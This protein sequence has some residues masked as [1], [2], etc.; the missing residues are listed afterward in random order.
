MKEIQSWKLF[1]LASFELC[2]TLAVYDA[3]IIISLRGEGEVLIMQP[4]LNTNL[5][6]F[7]L[8]ATLLIS[9]TRYHAKMQHTD[10]DENQLL[11]ESA[12]SSRYQWASTCFLHCWSQWHG[13]GSKIHSVLPDVPPQKHPTLSR[14]REI[15]VNKSEKYILWNQRNTNI[16]IL[17]AIMVHSV[18]PPR[19]HWQHLTYPNKR[20]ARD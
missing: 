11:W 5:P 3:I 20:D 2:K 9:S 19:K 14:I 13:L 15:W 18:F 8:P 12:G 4:L 10:I 7:P 1:A 16:A 6:S 17:K